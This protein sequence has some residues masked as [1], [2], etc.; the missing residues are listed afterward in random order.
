[1]DPNTDQDSQLLTE[2]RRRR[3]ELSESMQAVGQ[4]LAAPFADDAAAWAERVR[5]AVVELSG[6]FRE[7]LAITEGPEGLYRELE[8]QAVRLIGPVR[9]L[10]R[11]HA[12]IGRRV[13]ELLAGVE[14]DSPNQ[15]EWVRRTGTD[16]LVA[17]KRHRQ[18]GA[19]LVFAAYEIDIGG[20]T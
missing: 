6:D 18:R 15:A 10:T 12:D 4:A 7:H 9:L 16:L 13:A 1:M 5:A 2:L 14:A 19:D 20:E 11:E 8:L 3:A 17:L